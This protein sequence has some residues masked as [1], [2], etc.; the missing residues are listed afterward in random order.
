LALLCGCDMSLSRELRTE[1]PRYEKDRHFKQ[2]DQELKE[3][4][5][6]ESIASCCQEGT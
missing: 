6:Q 4:E 3:E 2:D 5:G 1:S